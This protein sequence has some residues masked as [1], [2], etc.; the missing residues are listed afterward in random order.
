MLID[1]HTH[2]FNDRIAAKALSRL[3][4]DF[5]QI[6]FTDGTLAGTCAKMQEWG[7]SA[8]T[9]LNIATKPGQQTVINDWA[10][11]VQNSSVFCFGSVHPD[12]ADAADEVSR[13]SSLG[14]YGIKLHPDYQNFS[15]TDPKAYPI[16]ETAASCGLPITF[17][18]GRDPASVK[19][20]HSTPEG[21]AEI[22]R[23]FPKLTIIAAHMGGARLFDE[24]ER[25]LAGKNVYLDTALAH[26]ICSPEQFRHM[27]KKHGSERILFGSD[28]PWQSPLEEFHWLERLNL[29][30]AELENI[31]WR[32]AAGLLHR[33]QRIL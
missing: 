3:S 23:L 7:V 13:I 10:A 18:V 12:A 1:M 24:A 27:V 30:D 11:A 32:N 6:P 28:C 33:G 5:H 29:P 21:I 14:L 22:S 25:F 4:K 26:L 8:F 16:Y 9:V 31:C 17:H 20:L 2:M 15:V 19:V